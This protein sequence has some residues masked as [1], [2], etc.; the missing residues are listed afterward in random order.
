MDCDF[1]ILC[2]CENKV[3]H[4]YKID[5]SLSRKPKEQSVEVYILTVGT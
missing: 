4:L 1:M 5:K 3:F 2:K